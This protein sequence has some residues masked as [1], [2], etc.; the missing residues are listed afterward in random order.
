M[1]ISQKVDYALRALLELAVLAPRGEPVR[2][3]QIAQRTQVPEKFLEAILVELRKAGLVESRRGPDG[4]HLLARAPR[5]ITLATIREAVDGPLSLAPR[6]SEGSGGPEGAAVRSMWAEVE[7]A[8]SGSG[9]R[10]ARRP[11]SSPLRCGT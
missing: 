1:K 7:R 4:G 3:A 5:E 11:R 6:A 10:P 2:S 8:T 9:C